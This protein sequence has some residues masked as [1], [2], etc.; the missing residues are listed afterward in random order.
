M[1][2]SEPIKK[3]KLLLFSR[4]PPPTKSNTS[5]HISSLKNDISLFS[6]LYLASQSQDGNLDEFLHHENQACP[7]SLSLH[8]KLRLG[9]RPLA[10]PGDGGAVLKPLIENTFDEYVLNV[11]L[12]YF[13]T[14]LQ[15]VSRVDIV[16]TST[17][18]T[19]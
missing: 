5:L 19:A 14:Q 15:R 2:I 8:G 16:W 9:N 17:T 7:P 13:F 4:P 10:L 11:F 3:N 1:P 6:R 12:P 18:K